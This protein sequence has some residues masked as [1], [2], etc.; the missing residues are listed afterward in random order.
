MGS[1]IL[2]IFSASLAEL[3]KD[4]Y[5]FEF[6]NDMLLGLDN[7]HSIAEQNGFRYVEKYTTFL[8]NNKS[9]KIHVYR[10]PKKH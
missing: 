10:E 4:R 5:R 7:R 2:S 1:L 6:E 3:E 9:E 8:L